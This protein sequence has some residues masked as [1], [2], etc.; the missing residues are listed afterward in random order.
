MSQ[1]LARKRALRSWARKLGIGS[2]SVES[3]LLDTAFTHDSYAAEHGGGREVAS[4]ER[5][6]FL[7]DAVLGAVVTHALYERHPANPEGALSRL[8][9]ALV[10]RAALAQTAQRLEIAPL[11]LLGRGETAAGGAQR[12]SILAAAL[13]AVVGALYLS[14]GLES[15]QRFIERHHLAHAA[16]FELTD[17]KTALQEYA[18]ARFKKAPHYAI[19]AQS[20]PPHARIF[21][22]TVSIAG[23]TAGFGSGNTIKQ[24]QTAAAREALDKI[25]RPVRT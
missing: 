20:G 23:K 5:L 17:P 16:A 15:V 19:A 25:R 1:Y 22:V 11:L 21:A 6:E 10:S 7:G 4:N 14:D 3:G 18:Q 9:A 12:P 2:A 24:A 8:R 13:E